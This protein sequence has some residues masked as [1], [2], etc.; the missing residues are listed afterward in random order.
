MTGKQG[1]SAVRNEKIVVTDDW[2]R[3]WQARIAIKITAIFLWVIILSGFATVVFFTKDLDVHIEQEISH[4]L[5]GVAHR[6]QS[7]LS[8]QGSELGPDSGDGVRLLIEEAI[9]QNGVEITGH[10]GIVGFRFTVAGQSFDFGTLRPGLASAKRQIVTPGGVGDET[11]ELEAFFLPAA[12]SAKQTRQELIITVV[13]VLLLFGMLLSLTIQNVLAKPLQAM[14][15]AIQQVSNGDLNLRLDVSRKDE[16]GHLS[17]FFNQMLSRVQTQQ[18]AL[19]EANRELVSEIAVREQAE[20]KLRAH[21]DTLEKVIEERT[22]DLEVARDQALAASQTKSAF[23][24]NVSHEIRTP[25]TPI[26]GFAE[27]MLHGGQDRREQEQSLRTII[28]NG[29][30]LSYIINE[31]LDLSKIEANSLDIESIAVDPFALLSDV[32]SIARVLADEK[33]LGFQLAY[34]FPIPRR[35]T[36]DPT[37]LKQILMNLVTNAI[38]FTAKGQVEI[39]VRYDTAA[40]QLSLTVSDTGIG[41]SRDKIER[42]FQ[43]FSQADYSTTRQ[44][45]GTGLGLYI[46]KRLANLLGG[47]ISLESVEGL[48]TRFAV[49]VSVGEVDDLE[50][51]NAVPAAD[52]DDLVDL[53]RL[54]DVQLDGNVLL[55]E[56]SPDIQRLMRYLL[57][58]TGARVT[59]VENGERAVEAALR[60]DYHLILMDMQMPVMG[61][62]EAVELLRASGCCTPIVALTANAMKEDRERYQAIGCDGFLPKP[63]EQ[64]KLYQVLGKYLPCRGDQAAAVESPGERQEDTGVGEIVAQFLRGLDDYARRIDA[65]LREQRYADAQELAHQLKGMGGAFGYPG[66]TACAAEL[67]VALKGGDPRLAAAPGEALVALL[68]S[69][70]LADAVPETA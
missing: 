6:V 2:T 23:V 1:D 63:V 14:M 65:A 60:E 36:S 52:R 56:D 3:N 68:N 46:S 61:G 44:Y 35:I 34:Q 39:A 50:L 45:G 20:Q 7:A 21:Q 43:P 33:G 24:A 41:I 5:D 15:D 10:A 26:I 4:D 42:L 8:R 37:R 59:A 58:R 25:L 69:T 18:E 51:A 12:D 57:Q 62:C 38:K 28:R 16:F 13:V 29:R 49:R 55:A 30:H 53:H 31:I 48:G 47:D 19:T 9:S 32:E 40:R 64:A 22:R 11:A 17:R 27:A 54:A 70:A 66:I 67:E